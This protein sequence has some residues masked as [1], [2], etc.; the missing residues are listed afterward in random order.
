MVEILD[1]TNVN[2][3]EE[4]EERME[5][6]VHSKPTFVLLNTFRISTKHQ[7]IKEAMK[8]WVA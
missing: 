8:Y 7:N 3:I 5:I 6:L 1:K 4:A 2:M